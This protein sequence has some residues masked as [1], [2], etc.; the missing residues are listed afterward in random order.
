MTIREVLKKEPKTIDLMILHHSITG[1]CN[2]CNDPDSLMYTGQKE[3]EHIED[4][5]LDLSVIG[6]DAIR[7]TDDTLLTIW[8]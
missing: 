6:Y 2:Y 8:I 3:I 5:V 4:E 1:Y 7:M